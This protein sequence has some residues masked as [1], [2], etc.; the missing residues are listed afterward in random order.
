MFE[1]AVEFPMTLQ[2]LVKRRVEDVR[3]WMGGSRSLLALAGDGALEGTLCLVD[4]DSRGRS[5]ELRSRSN[6]PFEE[7]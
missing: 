7:G 4:L 5:S 1:A 6:V 2:C 3:V